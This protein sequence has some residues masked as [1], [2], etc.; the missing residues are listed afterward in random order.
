MQKP[1]SLVVL[2]AVS[3][4]IILISIVMAA[5]SLLYAPPLTSPSTLTFDVKVGELVGLTIFNTAHYG[6]DDEGAEEYARLMPSGGHTIHLAAGDNRQSQEFTVT[7]FHQL[8]CLQIYHQEYLKKPRSTP[9]PLLRHC[10][11]YL[12]QSVLCHAD[13]RLE[14]IKNAQVQSSKEYETVCRDWTQVYDAAERNYAVY[15]GWIDTE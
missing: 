1:F 5:R 14:S 13:T 4:S 15:Q 6:L 9:T 10:L 7:L 12:R 2:S 8:K 11:N 3:A